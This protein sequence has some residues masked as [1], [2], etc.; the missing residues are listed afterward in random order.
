M[1]KKSIDP[2][3]QIITSR[4]PSYMLQ[5]AAEVNIFEFIG[6]HGT[7][8]E[9]LAQSSRLPVSSTR[10]LAQ[11]L[12]GLKLLKRKKDRIHHTDASRQILSDKSIQNELIGFGNAI[13]FSSIKNLIESPKKQPWYRMRNEKKGIVD[14]E[15]ISKPFF[16]SRMHHD[17][18]INKGRELA[19]IYPFNNHKRLLDIG[20][21]SGGWCIG[22]K[23]LFPQLQ[24]NVFD[25][26]EVCQLCESQFP[27]LTSM[28]INFVRGNIFEDPLP[29]G[30]DVILLANVLHDWSVD[31]GRTILT[32]VY[33]ALPEGGVVLASELFLNDTWE[34]PLDFMYQGITVLGPDGES[35]WQP[36][37]DEMEELVSSSGFGTVK[38]ES[39]LIIG[40]K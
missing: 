18:R 34:K 35:G 2:F 20:G 8:V 5:I 10:V 31:D 12:C 39:N 14:V 1:T 4:V 21:A 11:Y 27:E 33:D 9:T 36:S 6:E 22:I 26:P 25:L 38:R 17:W 37:F 30:A 13:T 3:Y 40:I 23:E 32:K 28:K 29:S 16:I 15:G 19:G 7:T 24:C